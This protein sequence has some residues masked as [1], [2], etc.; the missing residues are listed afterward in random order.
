MVHVLRLC[1][2]KAG[3]HYASYCRVCFAGNHWTSIQG[4]YRR[5][6]LRLQCTG[7][8]KGL[9]DWATSPLISRLQQVLRAVGRQGCVWWCRG[10]QLQQQEFSPCRRVVLAGARLWRQCL[11][12][13]SWGPVSAAAGIPS[14]G[15]GVRHDGSD[16]ACCC[17]PCRPCQA[18]MGGLNPVLLDMTAA[19]AAVSWG[20]I[21]APVCLHAWLTKLALLSTQQ[22]L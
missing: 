18:D 1:C 19:G 17:H 8:G 11:Q 21:A 13:G 22:M 7:V 15:Y 16:V 2:V 5:C 6:L 20:H 3:C 12:L 10:C 4:R 9:A 14:V